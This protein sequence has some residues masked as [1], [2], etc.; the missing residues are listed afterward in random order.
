[1]VMV[2][3]ATSRR[4]ERSAHSAGLRFSRCGRL[5]SEARTIA[6]SS[7][8]R[9]FSF[10]DGSRSG[11]DDE[12]GTST[13]RRSVDIGSGFS[14]RS[15]KTTSIPPN[16]RPYSSLP[17]TNVS[18]GNTGPHG[19]CFS[20]ASPGAVMSSTLRLGTAGDIRIGQKSISRPIS[21]ISDMLPQVPEFAQHWTVW[22]ASGYLLKT[23]HADGAV[24][25]WACMSLTNIVVRSSLVPLVIKSAHTQTRFAGVAPEVQFLVTCFQKDSKKLKEDGAPLGQRVD[26]ARKTFQTLRAIYKIRKVSPFDIFKSPL[27]QIPVF[28]YFSID[29]RKI[30]HGGDPELAQQLT[31]SGLLWVT[32][33]TEPDPWYGL[34]ILGGL[35][36]YANVEIAM[37]KK[38]LSGETTSK[39]NLAIMLKDFFQSLAIFMPCFMSHNPAGV[40]IYLATSFVFTAAQGAALRTDSIRELLGLPAMNAPAPEPV[41]VKEFL[42]MNKEGI[43]AAK[44]RKASGDEADMGSGV[45]YPGFQ[46]AFSGTAKPS[47]IVGSK[48]ID[49]DK[50]NSTI[51][52]MGKEKAQTEDG[53]SGVPEIQ[54]P[55]LNVG[56]GVLQ[57][58]MLQKP[59]ET[60]EVPQQE[61][62]PPAQQQAMEQIPEEVMEAAN[63]GE[64]TPPVEFAAAPSAQK[65]PAEVKKVNAKRLLEKKK[66]KRSGAKGTKKGVQ[67]KPRT[68]RK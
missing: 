3:R 11:E 9:H 8:L 46:T 65:K 44:K 56:L 25:Y 10:V 15:K 40:Q 26:L 35:L 19:A 23:L 58:T 50:N 54:K 62:S 68:R 52:S 48:G 17:Q 38:T 5:R 39:S 53:S 20:P 61:P 66:Q 28:W 67:R 47:T 2:Q 4:L 49:Q 1:M 42:D 27:M 6:C 60:E 16:R 18:S 36:L 31:E 45:L 63:R 64:W 22:G 13:S 41:L 57:P 37:G 12:V 55:N 34:P 43:D 33:L 32:D 51:I 29:I 24:P 14:M 59:K 7:P 30:I 21:S